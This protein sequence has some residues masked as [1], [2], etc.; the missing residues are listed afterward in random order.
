MFL[1]EQCCTVN[2]PYMFKTSQV[3]ISILVKTYVISAQQI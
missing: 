3:V 2:E 1:F